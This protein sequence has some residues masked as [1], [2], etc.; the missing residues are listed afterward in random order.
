MKLKIVVVIQ[1]AAGLMF[2]SGCATNGGPE[3]QG[4]HAQGEA[5][6]GAGIGALLGAVVGHQMG[7]TKAG[8]L[9]GGLVGGTVGYLHGRE[10]DLAQAQKLA[11]QAREDGYAA[12]VQ[13]ATVSDPQTHAPVQVFRGFQLAL[14]AQDVANGDPQSLMMLRQCG[15]L[16]LKENTTVNATGPTDVQPAV[17]SALALPGKRVQYEPAPGAPNVKLDVVATSG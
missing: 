12:Q 2:L 11:A 9:V 8:A 10:E 6:A 4:S 16:A 13:S 3:I 15:A 1:V 7:N 17:I 14:P 5:V